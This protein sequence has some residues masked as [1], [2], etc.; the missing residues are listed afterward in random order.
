MQHTLMLQQPSPAD[1]VIATGVQFSNVREF[2][3]RAASELG[4]TLAF[5]SEAEVAR[6]RRSLVAR[7][8]AAGRAM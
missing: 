5:E 8:P 6:V 3:E 7:R 1:F 2:V 4:I